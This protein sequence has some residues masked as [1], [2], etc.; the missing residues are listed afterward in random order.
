VTWNTNAS[1]RINSMSHVMAR[2]T[3]WMKSKRNFRVKPDMC[4]VFLGPSSQTAGQ[5][6][7]D[8][9][10]LLLEPFQVVNCLIIRHSI[11]SLLT[12]PLKNRR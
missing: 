6:R 11:T 4:F 10:R 3:I 8:K 12:L 1:S 5:Y 9:N 2:Y 7:L